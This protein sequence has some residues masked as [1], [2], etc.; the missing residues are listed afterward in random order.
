MI[1]YYGLLILIVGLGLW[2][3][4]DEKRG[5][6]RAVYCLA[7]TLALALT[8]GLRYGIGFDYRNYPPLFETI[9]SLSWG[10]LPSYRYELGFSALS[11]LL[12]LISSDLTFL[13]MVY[14]LLMMGV[15]GYVI[16]RRSVMPWF[17]FFY[18][19][20][21]AFFA[22]AMNL[23][24]QTFAAFIFLL[25]VPYLQKRRIVPY[26]L[27]VLLAASM[28]KTALLLIPVYFI[29]RLPLNRYTG[30][31]YGGG[32]VLVFLFSDPIM[33]FAMRYVFSYYTEDT[34]YYNSSSFIY[35]MVPVALSA[36][37]IALKGRLCKEDPDNIVYVN[38]MLYGGFFSLMMT[39][40]YILERFSLY[41]VVTGLLSV[42]LLAR[43]FRPQEGAVLEDDGKFRSERAQKLAL[44]R[45]EK[46][47]KQIYISV[48]TALC[49]LC[50][51]HFLISVN[52]KFHNVYPYYSIFSEEAKNQERIPYVPYWKEAEA[53]QR[54]ENQG[55]AENP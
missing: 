4:K 50:F 26:M 41:F 25:A 45:W 27:I 9:R 37:L 13:Y 54:L 31:L 48:I 51:I 33:H 49:L 2:W 38:L 43:T 20:T 1:I 42:P 44:R 10:E 36:L 14:A 23:L 8:A 39:R 55:K 53:A 19:V 47:Q 22:S 24:R 40:H 15:V 5:W 3:G 32:T 46:E 11:K 28:H 29:A 18:F 6:P 52:Y 21:L 17:S 16:W 12:M 35:V 34:I 7:V 30:A